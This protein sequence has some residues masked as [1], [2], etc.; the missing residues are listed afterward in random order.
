M[1]RQQEGEK[2]SAL[3][4]RFSVAKLVAREAGVLAQS[5]LADRS[6]LSVELKG[7]QDFVTEADRAVE[8]LI[9][10]Q[11][12]TAFPE[13]SL[14]G[15]EGFGNTTTVNSDAVWV[16][17]PIDGTANFVQG[18][19][20]WCV[21]IGL[22][23]H[24]RPAL[25]VVYQPSSDEIYAARRGHG[26]ARNGM[27]I[28]VSGRASISESTIALEYS[29]RTPIYTHLAQ[30]EALL[31]QGGEYRRNG[32]AALSL[33]YVSDG[34][35]DGY[36]EYDIYLWD[37]L[38]GLVLVTEAGGWTSDFSVEVDFR[39]GQSLVAGTPGI[40]DQLIKVMKSVQC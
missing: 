6:K 8:R 29:P 27:P 17:D 2:T 3:A 10:Q 9:V 34:R 31:S 16:I 24:D 5:F 12:S 35:F 21:S 25:G 39:R 4:H 20:E 18:R 37:V 22:L 15:E 1:D 33:A 26:A 23:Y 14:V 7:P 38:A 32:S 28:Q 40:Q 11:L 30:V 36:I 19:N 13:D